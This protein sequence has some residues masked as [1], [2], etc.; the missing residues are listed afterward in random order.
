MSVAAKHMEQ[1]RGSHKAGLQLLSIRNHLLGQLIRRLLQV[2]RQAEMN[3]EHQ[4]GLRPVIRE[5]LP[6]GFHDVIVQRLVFAHVLAQHLSGLHHQ[7]GGV[8]IKRGSDEVRPG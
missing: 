8:S 6:E 3:G 4:L 5:G 2:L 7:A 1:I